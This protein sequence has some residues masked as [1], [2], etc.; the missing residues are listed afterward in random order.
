MI[1]VDFDLYSTLEDAVAGRAPWEFCNYDDPSVGFPRDCG[2]LDAVGGNW[3]NRDWISSGAAQFYIL[4]DPGRTCTEGGP[5]GT[6]PG[7]SPT[8]GGGH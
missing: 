3:N 2:P 4:S 7:P 8:L 6:V 1:H 5:P